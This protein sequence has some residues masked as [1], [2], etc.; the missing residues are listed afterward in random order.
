MEIGSKLMGRSVE[1]TPSGGLELGE[2]CK[3]EVTLLQI[4]QIRTASKTV[5]FWLECP[6]KRG[7]ILLNQPEGCFQ[8]SLLNIYS[9]GAFPRKSI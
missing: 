6:R 7:G 4:S 3:W 2:A 8:F 9:V 1:K 5:L